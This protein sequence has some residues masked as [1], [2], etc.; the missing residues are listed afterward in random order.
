MPVDDD[1]PEIPVPEEWGPRLK[2]ARTRAGL[3]QAQLAAKVGVSQPTIHALESG[4]QSGGSKVLAL[5]RVLKDQGL[6]P[7][8]TPI[9]DDVDW[10]WAEAGRLL[11]HLA[12]DT[13]L[14]YLLGA[15]AFVEA[16][17]ARP[18]TPPAPA[19]PS[20]PTRLKP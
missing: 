13:M 14:G 1:D 19:S 6:V 11:R 16:A 17:A 8:F 7:P 18:P 9:R 15:E 4:K 12:P 20:D 5:C 10:R 2:E 3:S